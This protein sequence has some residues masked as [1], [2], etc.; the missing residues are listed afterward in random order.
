M[1][2]NFRTY[3]PFMVGFDN[4]FN[5]I[6]SMKSSEK[7]F[8]PYNLVKESANEFRIE[9]AVAGF[10][11]ED[12]EVSLQD[13]TLSIEGSAGKTDKADEE[14]LWRGIGKRAF[15]RTFAVAEGVMVHEAY[16]DNGLLIIRLS[17][18]EPE[19]E[20]KRIIPINRSQKELLTE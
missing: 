1:V 5:T 6:E 19:S 16:I 17:Y 2:N 11:D 15:K 14:Y 20:K 3:D 7:S 8:P 9:I 18:S 13:N 10:T 12:I 4:L